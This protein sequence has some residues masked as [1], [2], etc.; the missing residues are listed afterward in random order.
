VTML[1][2]TPQPGNYTWINLI[3]KSAVFSICYVIILLMID[4]SELLA[5][6]RIVKRN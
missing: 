3:A 5:L 2:I 4:R 1:M 6:Y